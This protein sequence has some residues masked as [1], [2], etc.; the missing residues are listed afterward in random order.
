MSGGFGRVW[1]CLVVCSCWVVSG[2]VRL[3]LGLLCLLAAM[4][5]CL[6]QVRSVS[7]C[8]L[9]SVCLCFVIRFVLFVLLVFVFVCVFVVVKAKVGQIESACL[10]MLLISNNDRAHLAAWSSGMILA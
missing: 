1:L 5:G 9:M 2:H 7:L 8:Q 10:Y 4:S 6:M 3:C